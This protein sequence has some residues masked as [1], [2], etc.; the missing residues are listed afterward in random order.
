MQSTTFMSGWWRWGKAL[1]WILLLA[2][3]K[4]MIATIYNPRNL[5]IWEHKSLC[6]APCILIILSRSIKGN[7]T[8]K[9][10]VEE[11]QH[12]TQFSS[13][14]QAPSFVLSHAVNL[15]KDAPPRRSY[16]Y[17]LFYYIPVAISTQTLAIRREK[18]WRSPTPAELHSKSN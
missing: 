1:N 5:F 18:N 15:S 8:N 4:E 2:C 7:L 13:N 10:F 11:S 3:Y 17:Q 14:W 9:D 6:L 16:G 12:W